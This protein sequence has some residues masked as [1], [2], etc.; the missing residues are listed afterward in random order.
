[1]RILLQSSW[2]YHSGY[3][4]DILIILS[5]WDRSRLGPHRRCR[6]VK[7]KRTSLLCP[8]PLNGGIKRWWPWSVCPSVCSLPDPKSITEGLRKL[9]IGGKEAHETDDQLDDHLEVERSTSPG[10]L[11]SWPKISR[12][13][14]TGMLT[15][16]KLGI[17]MEYMTRTTSK[18]DD[19]Q[20]E[21]SGWLFKTPLAGGGGILWPP[22][23]RP[24]SLFI[25]RRCNLNAKRTRI[26]GILFVCSS[27]SLTFTLCI[28][29]KRLN[30]SITCCEVFKYQG[31]YLK[32]LFKALYI[33]FVVFQIL[34]HRTNSCE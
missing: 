28:V 4:S 6:C 29:S 19:L 3:E 30:V 9:K 16:F 25:V 14:G 27:I 31:R 24:H 11:A 10:R 20:P 32:T 7:F 12:I 17:R 23:Y 33:V 26:Q 21:S 15:Y 8:A 18:R 13:F 5:R 34:S 2:V 22:H 1:M